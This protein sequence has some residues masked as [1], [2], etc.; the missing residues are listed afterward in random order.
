MLQSPC[1]T[2]HTFLNNEKSLFILYFT[3]L[4]LSAHVYGIISCINKNI[5]LI[6]LTFQLLWCLVGQLPWKRRRWLHQDVQ[7]KGGKTPRW[8]QH[9][10]VREHWW[11]RHWGILCQVSMVTRWRQY[12]QVWSNWEVC[13]QIPPS[14]SRQILKCCWTSTSTRNRSDKIRLW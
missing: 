12:Q 10:N 4:S 7:W 11:H 8:N 9:Q 13:R 3:Q 2:I 14:C 5:R 6:S 1:K